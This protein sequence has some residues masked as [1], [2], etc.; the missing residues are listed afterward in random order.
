MAL[1]VE[2]L[3]PEMVRRMYMIATKEVH[4]NASH[5]FLS[6]VFGD[7]QILKD[8]NFVEDQEVSVMILTNLSRPTLHIKLCVIPYLIS[9][10]YV[11]YSN[12]SALLNTFHAVQG[13]GSVTVSNKC[14][15]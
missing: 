4:P 10:I 9:S 8:F 5:G 12:N 13:I 3:I 1:D 7:I 15:H 14:N 2:V 6:R 11:N